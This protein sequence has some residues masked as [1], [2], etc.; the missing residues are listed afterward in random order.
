[1]TTTGVMISMAKDGEKGGGNHLI[2]SELIGWQKGG[3]F[4]WSVSLVFPDTR[5]F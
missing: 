4:A 3:S 2:T 1:M 5:E